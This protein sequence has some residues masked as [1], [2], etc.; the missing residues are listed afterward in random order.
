MNK[1]LKYAESDINSGL[2]YM[3]VGLTNIIEALKESNTTSEIIVTSDI[4]GFL[5]SELIEKVY[6]A[7]KFKVCN[8]AYVV[9]N[10]EDHYISVICDGDHLKFQI[11]NPIE[12]II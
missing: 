11:E 4:N 9:F 1:Y 2:S 10:I 3:K 6:P 7:V 12:N 8:N 5:L